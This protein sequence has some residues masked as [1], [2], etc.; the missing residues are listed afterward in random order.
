M[1]LDGGTMFGRKRKRSTWLGPAL[2]AGLSAGAIAA[3]GSQFAGL[4]NT[5][6]RWLGDAIKTYTGFG[7]YTVNSNALYEGAQAPFV[8]NDTNSNGFI[9]SHREY[10]YDITTAPV[11]GAFKLDIHTLNPGNS[12]LF[13]YLAQIACNYEQYSLEGIIFTYRATSADSSNSTNIALGTVIM[14][15]DYNVL[16]PAPTSKAELT[17]KQYSMSCKP[18][19]DMTFPIECAPGTS[20]STIY[21]I[22]TGNVEE[23]ADLRLYDFANVYVATSGYQGTNVVIGELWVS[24]QVALLKPRL[25]ASLGFFEEFLWQGGTVAPTA[26]NIWGA[27]FVDAFSSP[28]RSATF[29]LGYTA[30]ANFCDIVMPAFPQPCSYLFSITIYNTAGLNAARAATSWTNQVNC[31]ITNQTSA[32]GPLNL[33]SVWTDTFAVN[34]VGGLFVPS[35]RYGLTYGAWAPTNCHF[36]ISQMPTL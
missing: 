3:G 22:R 26:A 13:E 8:R 33:S 16:V 27:P 4:A 29:T 30:G 25:Y 20:M 19:E 32:P 1:D 14:G 28:H 21:C 7:A 5:G 12:Q 18:S 24:Y 6:G 23:N 31:G 15:A 10:I 9:V 34:C 36:H 17:A 2:G 11:A 35:F